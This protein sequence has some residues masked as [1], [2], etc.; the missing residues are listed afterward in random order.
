MT[1]MTVDEIE[2]EVFFINPECVLGSVFRGA[3]P[4][5]GVGAVAPEHVSWC[6]GLL[7]M[8]KGIYALSY[9]LLRKSSAVLCR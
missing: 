7:V 6:G 3:R 4:I 5:Q 2:K 1:V 9:A 8:R